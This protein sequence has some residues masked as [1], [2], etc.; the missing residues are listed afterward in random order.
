MAKNVK[1]V[2]KKFQK[3]Y[4]DAGGFIKKDHHLD[5]LPKVLVTKEGGKLYITQN[6]KK[7]DLNKLPDGFV[8]EGTLDLG[9]MGLTKLPN[10]SHVKINGHFICSSNPLTSLAGAPK[11]V[12]SFECEYTN[13]TNLVGAPEFA[14]NVYV[15]HNR[16]TSLQGAPCVKFED[17]SYSGDFDCSYNQLTS[18]RGLRTPWSSIYCSSN[19]LKRLE[20]VSLSQMSGK[21]LNRVK[22][23]LGENL[24][25]LDYYLSNEIISWSNNPCFYQYA[26]WKLK[27]SF[28]ID[29]PTREDIESVLV[30]MEYAAGEMRR[31]TNINVGEYAHLVMQGE[32]IFGDDAGLWW[33]ANGALTPEDIIAANIELFDNKKSFARGSAAVKALDKAKQTKKSMSGVVKTSKTK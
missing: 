20:V 10:M 13:I 5:D 18:L 24:G 21:A 8:I 29:N 16:L 15:S 4:G 30:L 12:F 2:F 7:Y 23:D 3:A 6:G 9:R 1:N 19:N 11:E 17:G 26:E 31:S 22:Q 25:D 32:E 27:N 28:G 14:T 33:M